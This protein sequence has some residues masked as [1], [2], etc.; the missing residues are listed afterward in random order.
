[1]K[2]IIKV[3]L[4]FVLLF[5]LRVGKIK[6]LNPVYDIRVDKEI[7]IIPTNTPVPTSIVIKPIK[8]IEID[9][10]PLATKTPTAIVVTQIVT[11]TPNPT[12]S[13]TN[14]KPTETEK[15]TTTPIAE[16]TV[17]PEPTV[18][19]IKTDEKDNKDSSK[20]F[21]IIIVGFLTLILIVQIWSTRENKEDKDE[22]D[23]IQ[24]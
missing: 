12:V 3:V 15:L 6:A 5:G 16:E 4:C 8:E 20:W 17:T 23:D 9:I 10:M 14:N 1:M 7:K 22:Q 2:N 19:E 24:S 13:E 11:V 21:W 18:E